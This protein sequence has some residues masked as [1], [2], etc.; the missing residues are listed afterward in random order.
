MLPQSGWDDIYTL[1][2]IWEELWLSSEESRFPGRPADSQFEQISTESQIAQWKRAPTM[3]S[4]Q[5]KG[6]RR[7]STYEYRQFHCYHLLSTF[8]PRVCHSYRAALNRDLFVKKMAHIV[9]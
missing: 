1:I 3:S 6:K 7:S 2:M 8:N 5:L 4:I 9:R